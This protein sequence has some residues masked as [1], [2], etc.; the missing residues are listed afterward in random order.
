MQPRASRRKQFEVFWNPRG[1]VV[2]LKGDL[3]KLC[4]LLHLNV[5]SNDTVDTLK[6]KI[7]PMLAILKA[8]PADKSKAKAKP[9][10]IRQHQLLAYRHLQDLREIYS[11]LV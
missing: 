4:H 2:S 5:A 7:K 11:K 10:Q 9:L 8:N 3:I 1:G 6:E